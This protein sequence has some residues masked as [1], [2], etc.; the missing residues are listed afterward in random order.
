VVDLD[1]F[2]ER[3]DSRASFVAF[4]DALRADLSRELARPA[5]ETAFGAG[6]WSHAFA[7]MLLAARVYE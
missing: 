1:E 5:E 6:D 4:L 3:V 7:E 2:G